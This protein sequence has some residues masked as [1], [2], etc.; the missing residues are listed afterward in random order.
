MLKC[1]RT[2]VQKYIRPNVP[3]I[4]LSNGKGTG[5]PNYAKIVS[6]LTRENEY[7][8]ESI[9]F[10]R[11][12]FNSFVKGSITSCKKRS[13]KIYKSCFVDKTRLVEYYCKAL[14]LYNKLLDEQL[15]GEQSDK[16]VI[17]DLSTRISNLYLEYA[18]SNYVSTIIQP[19]IVYANKRTSADFVDVKIPNVSINKWQAV[20]DLMDYGD[21]E[22][23]IYRQLFRD[24]CIRIEIRLPDCNGEIKDKG[25][26]YYIEDPEPVFPAEI[27]SDMLKQILK[28]YDDKEYAK[29]QLFLLQ[30][31]ERFN[32]KQSAWFE[33]NNMLGN[34]ISY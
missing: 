16:K 2:W 34:N 7:S 1:S 23:T 26:V 11:D 32:I 10:D 30:D 19:A 12:A 20:H 4:Y 27:N 8:N 6:G 9:Y 15:L 31:N 22:E 21:I 13:K 3:S 14:E 5:K 24:G 33:Y 28:T 17:E 25:K 18:E 29:S